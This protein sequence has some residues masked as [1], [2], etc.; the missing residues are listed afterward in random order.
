MD[1]ISPPLSWEHPICLS[2]SPLQTSNPTITCCSSS[3]ILPPSVCAIP[4]FRSFGFVFA[5]RGGSTQPAMQRSQLEK[6]TVYTCKLK[7]KPPPSRFTS[8]GAHFNHSQLIWMGRGQASFLLHSALW[9]FIAWIMLDAKAAAVILMTLRFLSPFWLF[10]N[11]GDI[12][13]ER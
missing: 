3:F 12:K 5:N 11:S 13:L 1:G 9:I 10:W 6:V 7:G 8:R 2:S 4:F